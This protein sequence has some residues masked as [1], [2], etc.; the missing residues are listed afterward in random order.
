M[1]QYFMIL[2]QDMRSR[3]IKLVTFREPF[4]SAADR[5]PILAEALWSPDISNYGQLELLF[6]GASRG[7]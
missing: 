1:T 4:R 3:V 7:P 5:A 2:L 6:R